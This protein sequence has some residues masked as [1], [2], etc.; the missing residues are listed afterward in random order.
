MTNGPEG[1]RVRKG[2]EVQASAGHN[3]FQEAGPVLHPL[4]PGLHQRDQPGEVALGLWA[5]A[6]SISAADFRAD[7]RI[8]TL[9]R[10][11]LGPDRSW[12]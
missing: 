12:S 1:V 6:A 11:R 5:A 10:R 8:G 2:R 9:V 4:E 7:L 3:P